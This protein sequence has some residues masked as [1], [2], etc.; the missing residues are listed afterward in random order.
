MTGKQK[1]LLITILTLA[2]FLRLWRLG[3]YPALNADEASIGYDAYSLIQT[4]KDQHGNSWPIH[5]QS[6][7]DFKPGLV[8]YI[9]IPFVKLFGLN[10]WSI[11]LP[12]ALFGVATVYALF[13]LVNQLFN[14]HRNGSPITDHRSHGLIAAFLLAISPWH[15]HFSRGIWEVNVA[16]FYMLLGPYL[17]IRGLKNTVL[18]FFSSL[19]LSLSLYTYHSARVVVPLLLLGVL[20][21]YKKE[22]KENLRNI[23]IAGVIGLIL[24]LPLGYDLTK[25]AVFSRA[26]GVGLFADKG[27]IERINE[28]RGEHASLD[29]LP[30]KAIHNKV[31]N[32][33]LE[34]LKNY[35]EHY[36]GLFLFVSGEE[37][38]RNRVPET[39]QMYLFDILFVLVG[40]YVITRIVVNKN[41]HPELVS[42]SGASKIPKLVRND[43]GMLIVLYWLIVAPIAAGLTFQSPHALRSQNMVIPLVIISSVGVIKVVEW[44][45]RLNKPVY[46]RIGL[47]TLGVLVFWNFA[48][49]EHMY[50]THMSKEYP[51]SSQ[52]GLEELVDYV[53]QEQNKYEGVLV[54]DKYDQPYIMFLFY[55]RYPPSDFQ[56]NHTLTTPD[57][58]GFSTVRS[59]GKYKFRG[60][61]WDED[62][63]NYPG[64][65]IVDAPEGVPNDTDIVKNIYGSNHYEYFKVVSN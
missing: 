50:W 19:V 3:E 47:L 8:V 52:Y 62:R 12:G 53:N 46:K 2:A 54:T 64:S 4:G 35:S 40:L 24:V 25:G 17:F 5:F 38:E 11:R 42:G 59:F 37:I 26:A 39:G 31:V 18:L 65:L 44:F 56:N 34:F 60:I 49:Y 13:L 41:G 22:V 33:G 58:Y 63:S 7:N 14:K 15:L 55:L 27:S 57:K 16:T 32:Y 10:S 43:K 45:N 30:S 21:I 28:Q 29:S 51:F 20:F 23:L 61:N 36:H 6:F 48:R 1:F 9:V